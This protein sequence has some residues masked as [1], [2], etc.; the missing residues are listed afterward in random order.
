MAVDSSGLAALLRARH[1]VT[2]AGVAFRFRR[3][4]PALRRAVELSGFQ[5]L[6]ADE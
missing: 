5:A 4:S 2:E 3:P 6:L 1:A